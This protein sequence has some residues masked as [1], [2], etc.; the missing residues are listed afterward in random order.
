MAVASESEEKIKPCKSMESSFPSPSVTKIDADSASE[1]SS[2]VSVSGNDTDRNEQSDSSI[3]RRRSVEFQSVESGRSEEYKLLFRLPSDE[4]LIRDFNCALQ[5]NILLQGHMYLFLHHICFYSNIFGFETKRIIVFHEVTCVRKAKT[6]AIFPNAIE[7]VAGGKK[8]FFASFLSRD[9]AYRLIVDG[10]SQNSTSDKSLCE[11][12]ESKS[13]TGS[14]ENLLALFERFKTNKQ[15]SN[16]SNFVERNRNTSNSEESRSLSSNEDDNAVST[17]LSEVQAN[18]EEEN[19]QCSLQGE[20]LNWKLEDVDAPKIPECYTM[21][22][23]SKFQIRIEEFFRLFFSNDAVE[24]VETFHRRCGDKDFKCTSWYEHEQFG[25]TRDV[26]FQHPIKIYLGPKFGHCQEVQKFRAYR[27]RHL[28]IEASQ[29]IHDVPYGD[30]FRVEGLWDVEEEGNEENGCCI[31]R[32][33]VHVAFSKKTIWKGKIE[34]STYEECRETY[35]AWIKNA[36]ELLKQRQGLAELEGDVSDT[37]NTNI[38]LCNVARLEEF[39]NLNGT[40]E[41]EVGGGRTLS[42]NSDV[43]SEPRDRVTQIGNPVKGDLMNIG[44]SMASLFRESWTMFCL[45]LKSQRHFPMMLVITI[46]SILIIMQLCIIVLLVK[47]PKVQLISGENFINSP[48]GDRSVARAWL[49]KRAYHLMDE[50]LMVETRL[51]QMH[52]EY[53]LLKT[54]LQCLKQFK[55]ES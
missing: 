32:V 50:M 21:V 8:H 23:E 34:Q 14:Q 31:L 28:I 13:D 6:A 30:H 9:E 12:Q 45:Y 16:D 1:T 41:E 40:L 17:K 3:Q 38:L 47:P 33:Y 7:I 39:A 11:Q 18:G 49:E 15:P 36:H 2:A 53:V 10:W 37:A 55:T 5:E 51:E 19:A 4:V 22:A 44:T 48:S 24:F 52:S 54:H 35:A 27:N 43:A 46:I 26:S 29:Q 42:R 25:H 20:F